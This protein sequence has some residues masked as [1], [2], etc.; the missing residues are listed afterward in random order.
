[1]VDRVC[2]NCGKSFK[3]QFAWT[4]KRKNRSVGGFFCSKICSAS[5]VEVRNKIR[6]SKLGYK[7]PNWKNG[8]M[9]SRGYV[10]LLQHSHP[11]ANNHGYVREHRLIMEKKIGRYLRPEEIV[12]HINGI[13]NDN[14][15]ENLQLFANKGK[16]ISYHRGLTKGV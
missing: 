6:Q 7:N 2:R 15:K 5:S 4:K 10:Y 14:R 9:L 3:T 11:F 8:T 1:M 12:H 16:H 13:V